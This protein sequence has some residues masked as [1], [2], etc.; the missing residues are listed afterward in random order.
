MEQTV[1]FNEDDRLQV[2]RRLESYFSAKLEQISNSR[3]CFQDASGKLYCIIGASGDW[4]GIPA[5]IFESPEAQMPNSHL[6]IAKRYQSKIDIFKGSLVTLIK[7]KSKLLRN[8][9]GDYQFHSH[10]VGASL[11]IE[12]IPHF[13]LEKIDEINYSV[14]DSEKNIIRELKKIPKRELESLLKEI[15]SKDNP[16]LKVSKMRIW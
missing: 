15:A 14:M 8:K 6:I 2:I 11:E 9:K 10:I 5:R 3:K 7:N 1:K 12:D 4:H 16:C 13:Y